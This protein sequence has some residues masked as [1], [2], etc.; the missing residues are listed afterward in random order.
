MLGVSENEMPSEREQSAHVAAAAWYWTVVKTGSVVNI[1][2]EGN[3]LLPPLEFPIENKGAE[4]IMLHFQV[5]SKG[6]R[7]HTLTTNVALYPETL[8]GGVSGC[9]KAIVIVYVLWMRHSNPTQ[10]ARHDLSLLCIGA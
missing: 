6:C 3:S 8:P 7:L 10:D 4:H 1:S 5:I 9:S 2:P